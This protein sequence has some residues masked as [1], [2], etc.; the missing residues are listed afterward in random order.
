[1]SFVSVGVAQKNRNKINQRTQARARK[2]EAEKPVGA[3]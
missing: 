2:K 3:G 1:M